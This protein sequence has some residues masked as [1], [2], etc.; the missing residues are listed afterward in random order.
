SQVVSW[1]SSILQWVG[2]SLG[3]V[4]VELSNQQLVDFEFT[5]KDKV[6]RMLLKDQLTP[7]SA[8]NVL[9]QLPCKSRSISEEM[10]RSI[11]ETPAANALLRESREFCEA[12][13][14]EREQ[15]IGGYV[16]YI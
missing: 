16:S 10:L 11:S 5:D 4:K 3:V 12:V 2:R 14:Q 15:D 7:E 9:S 8:R 1:L 6:V 13:L